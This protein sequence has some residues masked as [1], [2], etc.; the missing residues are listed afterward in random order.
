[1]VIDEKEIVKTHKPV[2]SKPDAG[3]VTKGLDLK[4]DQ[5]MFSW[6]KKA[7]DAVQMFIED[8]EQIAVKF[9]EVETNYEI[10]SIQGASAKINIDHFMSLPLKVDAMGDGITKAGTAKTTGDESDL[11]MSAWCV[12]HITANIEE[13]IS[14][15][16]FWA[17]KKFLHEIVFGQNLKLRTSPPKGI[18]K[19]EMKTNK[20]VWESH[21]YSVSMTR[22]AYRALEEKINKTLKKFMKKKDITLLRKAESELVKVLQK[23]MKLKPGEFSSS[24]GFGNY[25][26]VMFDAMF[27]KDFGTD[28]RI[29]A[30]KESKE[31]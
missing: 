2:V 15:D 1:M 11:F 31:W 18:T 23:S 16:N 29:K 17:M 14:R 8:G 6:F 4:D 27:P 12:N 21:K 28:T 20:F 22:E 13:K 30:L 5:S 26:V 24:K 3:T 10:F 9:S 19:S 25:F 7:D